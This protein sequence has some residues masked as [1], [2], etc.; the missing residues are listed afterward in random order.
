M[1]EILHMIIDTLLMSKRKFT[2]LSM[3]LWETS[4]V[5]Q[6]KIKKKGKIKI[7]KYQKLVNS[8]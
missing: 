5:K 7:I 4:W 3:T 2:Q 6:N 1:L 8:S